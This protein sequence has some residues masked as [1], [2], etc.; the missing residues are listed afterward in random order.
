MK[1]SGPVLQN[2]S[3]GETVRA[4]RTARRLT[5]QDLASKADLA[6]RTVV[7]LETGRRAPQNKTRRAIAKALGVRIED[8]EVAS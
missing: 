7:N 6:L 4:M 8:L 1:S 3:V 2:A 5:Q